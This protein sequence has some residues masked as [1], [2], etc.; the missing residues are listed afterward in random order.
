MCIPSIDNTSI[1]A[2]RTSIGADRTSIGAEHTSVGAERT[3]IGTECCFLGAN[4]IK[5]AYIRC[6]TMID[7]SHPNTA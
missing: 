5:G 6:F 2:E 1:G 4:G 3:S 7:K